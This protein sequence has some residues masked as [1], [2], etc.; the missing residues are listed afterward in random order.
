MYTVP[1]MSWSFVFD[2]RAPLQRGPGLGVQP[3][4]DDADD[5]EGDQAVDVGDGPD[6][7]DA[8]KEEGKAKTRDY[9]GL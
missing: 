6:A 1:D 4:H 9:Q 3:E 7:V 5:D 2:P 8:S